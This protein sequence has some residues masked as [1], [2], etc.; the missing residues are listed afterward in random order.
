MCWSS[1]LDQVE[2]N[3]GRQSSVFVV[4]CEVRSE[5]EARGDS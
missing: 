1:G 3:A 4:A 5:G 2:A